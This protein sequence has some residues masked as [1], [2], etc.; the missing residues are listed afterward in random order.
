MAEL[1]PAQ[2]QLVS[3]YFACKITAYM[4]PAQFIG[5]INGSLRNKVCLS[6]KTFSIKSETNNK[7]F[8]DNA[9]YLF[10]VE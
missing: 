6:L 10:S 4:S 1:G 5:E 3:I 8:V 2:P 9:V 7:F